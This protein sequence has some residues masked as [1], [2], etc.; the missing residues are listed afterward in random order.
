MALPPFDT[1]VK[2]TDQQLEDIA[3]TEFENLLASVGAHKHKRYRAVWNGCKLRSQAAKT[4][5]A[6]MIAANKAMHEKFYELSEL[7]K[8]I[9]GQ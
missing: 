8:N 2:M 6:R 7:L 3:E 5:E 4:P 9:T 1:L